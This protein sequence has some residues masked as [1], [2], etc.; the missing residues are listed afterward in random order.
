[1]PSQAERLLDLA[2]GTEVPSRQ[3]AVVGHAAEVQDRELIGQHLPRR[4]TLRQ[5]GRDVALLPWEDH[6]RS[7]RPPPPPVKTVGHWC[8]STAPW[9]P[10]RLPSPRSPTR[11]PPSARPAARTRSGSVWPRACAGCRSG[12]SCAREGASAGG[13]WPIRA[14]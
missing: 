1:R 5:L 12:I 8:A 2:P 10:R 4:H 9:P 13:G 3:V 11:P 6:A 14:G 7:I